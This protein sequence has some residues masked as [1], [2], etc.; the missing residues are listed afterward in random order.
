M[1]T[2]CTTFRQHKENAF[3][4]SLLVAAY[5][6]F[7]RT[8]SLY[9][10]FIILTS[11][12]YAISKNPF[13]IHTPGLRLCYQYICIQMRKLLKL[14]DRMTDTKDSFVFQFKLKIFSLGLNILAT[15]DSNL[16]GS[17]LKTGQ[18]FIFV[19]I[20]LLLPI[21][22]I[23]FDSVSKILFIYFLLSIIIIMILILKI[24]LHNVYKI[25]NLR[26][27]TYVYP[28][29]IFLIITKIE[30]WPL[31]KQDPPVCTLASHA[32]EGKRFLP[33]TENSYF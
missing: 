18:H 4:V 10:T 7:L 31:F 29:L 19:I 25:M 24:L 17:C 8:R 20:Y 2:T 5:S 27:P 32:L 33:A 3:L 11:F 21:K 23:I 16:S 9:I 28:F 12:K 13:T 6:Y 15:E 22:C 14:K 1:E 30:C 26:Y